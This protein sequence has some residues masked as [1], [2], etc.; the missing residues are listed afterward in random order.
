MRWR[1]VPGVSGWD[2]G[3]NSDVG[4]IV[5]ATQRRGVDGAI[6]RRG[7]VGAKTRRATG[8][9]AITVSLKRGHGL[10]E[11]FTIASFFL[12]LFPRFPCPPVFACLL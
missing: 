8:M 11:C 6:K 5:G 12:Y 10:F 1:M 9:A 2:G 3:E 7:I 4:R